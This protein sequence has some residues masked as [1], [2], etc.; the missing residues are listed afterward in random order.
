M[1]K[2]QVYTVKIYFVSPIDLI[3]VVINTLIEMEYEA[4]TVNDAER[5]DLLKVLPENV[6]SVVFF[7]LRSKMESDHWLKYAEKIKQIQDTHILIGAFSYD[8]MEQ[9]TKNKFL[10]QNIS[11]IEFSDIQKNTVNVMKNI[12]MYFDAKG[13]RGYIRTKAYGTAEAYFYMK[14]RSDPI[15]A[16]VIDISAFA[17]SCEVDEMEKFYFTKNTYFSEVLFVLSGIR[18]RS[19]VKVLGFNKDKKTTIIL[20]FCTA[21]M[22]GGRLIY[23]E[24]IVPEINRKI[25]DYIRKCLKDEISLKFS[26]Q[27]ETKGT[28]KHQKE[29]S[30]SETASS[31]PL[32][33]EETKDDSEEKKDDTVKE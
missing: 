23:E 26:G 33:T 10:E 24:S 27:P 5:D 8:N 28:E 17:F 32:K 30:K 20:K 4:Y 16:K 12:L 11:V 6:R 25:H 31:V 21:R 15:L 29:S 14:N 9:E 3:S 1:D 2:D 13:K 7:C 18:I 19:A 22:D